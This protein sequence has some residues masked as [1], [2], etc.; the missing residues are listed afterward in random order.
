[1]AKELPAYSQWQ[2]EHHGNILPPYDNPFSILDEDEAYY[3]QQEDEQR[4]FEE[5]QEQEQSH[6]EQQ[7]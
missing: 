4:Q 3:R 5:W 1:M 6:S 7:F 2:L